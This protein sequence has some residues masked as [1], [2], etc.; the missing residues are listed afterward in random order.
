MLS[1]KVLAESLKEGVCLMLYLRESGIYN[2][3]AKD[4]VI[5]RWR[6]TSRLFHNI[7]SLSTVKK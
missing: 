1:M 7:K 3:D 5:R 2:G 4:R 6:N